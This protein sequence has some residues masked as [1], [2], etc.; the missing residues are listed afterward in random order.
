MGG[1]GGSWGIGTGIGGKEERG[2][3]IKNVN[4]SVY[5]QGQKSW[6]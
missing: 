3:S 2:V 5:F 1:G 6:V 4:P